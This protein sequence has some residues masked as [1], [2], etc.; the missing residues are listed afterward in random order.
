MH[1]VGGT[2]G[3]TVAAAII[4][5]ERQRKRLFRFELT[6]IVNFFA[7]AIVPLRA[8]A[9]P[10]LPDIS[11]IVPNTRKTNT[12]WVCAEIYRYLRYTPL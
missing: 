5:H 9:A 7:L 4:N 2:F 11:L 1:I 6:P 10:A 8:L 12:T 3:I